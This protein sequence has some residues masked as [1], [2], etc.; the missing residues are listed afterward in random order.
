MDSWVEEASVPGGRSAGIGPARKDMDLIAAVLYPLPLSTTRFEGFE[1]RVTMKIKIRRSN[2]KYAK[3][4][5][6]LT[7]M[8]TRNGRAILKRQR[9]RRLGL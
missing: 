7:R 8:K 3:K 4:F 1:G 9:K 2:S 5:G 6:F